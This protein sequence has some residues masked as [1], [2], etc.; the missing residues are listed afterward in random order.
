MAFC[1]APQEFLLETALAG[2]PDARFRMNDETFL[3]LSDPVSIH[4]VMNGS[5]DDFEKGALSE[6]PRTSWRD[7][8]LTAEGDSWREQHGIIAPLFARRRIGQLEPL[9]ADLAARLVETWA[10]LP[11]GEP[12]DILGAANRLAFDVV[13][14]GLL[15]VE[16]QAL[17]DE[18]FDCLGD[19]D[20]A[21]SVRINYLVKRYGVDVK[22]G[23]GGF[24]RSAHGQ[25]VERMGRLAEAAADE[26]LARTTQPDDLVGGVMATEAFSAFTPERKRAFLA[27]QIGTLLAAGY[28]TTGESIF[29]GLYLLAKHPAAQARARTEILEETEA[30]RG[31]APMA[32][33][34]FVVA[35]FNE[36]QRLYPPVWFLGRVALRDVRV[37][38]IDIAAGT[39]VICS[40]YV[41]HRMPGLWQDSEQYRPERFLPDASPAVAPR[42]HIPFGAGM[43]ACLGRALAQMEISAIACMTLAR[44]ELELVADVPVTLAAAFSMHPR[45]PVLFR[46]KPLA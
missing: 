28:I 35:A 15:G 42:S 5:L 2:G 31:T 7:G 44:F 12:V 21:D 32:A 6:I 9:I 19:L 11:E 22:G 17:A 13:A 38:D 36:S 37:G 20:R 23:H 8:I 16:D 3:V 10:A 4:A 25:V 18:L 33:P 43:R 39:R 29:W 46:L 45:E 14:K 27:D 24:G 34:P 41:L 40:P 30:D 26:R 1:R